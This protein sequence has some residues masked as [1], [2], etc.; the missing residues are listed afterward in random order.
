M[1]FGYADRLK[2]KK[3]VGGSLGSPEYH[4][5]L[6]DVASKMRRV[7]TLVRACM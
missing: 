7:A 3:D 6:D 4:D 5:E 2:Q 1:S